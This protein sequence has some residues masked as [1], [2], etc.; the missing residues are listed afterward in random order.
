MQS[1]VR[2]F[3]LVLVL[4]RVVEKFKPK[5]SASVPDLLLINFKMLIH[6]LFLLPK[7]NRLFSGFYQ[8]GQIQYACN[9]LLA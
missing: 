4:L 5:G 7:K 3:G 1:S 6:L 2:K 8:L 9:S